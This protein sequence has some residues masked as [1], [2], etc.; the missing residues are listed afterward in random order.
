ME[1]ALRYRFAAYA[2]RCV[3]ELVGLVRGVV[4]DGEV[5]ETEVYRLAAWVE[6]NRVVTSSWPGSAIAQRLSRIFADGRVE[7]E[8]RADLRLLLEDLVAQPSA[9]A[10]APD[11]STRLPLCDPPPRVAYEPSREFVFTGR[12]VFGTRGHCE[13]AVRRRGASVGK[14][15]T[16]RTN[17]LVIGQLGSKAWVHSTHGR[18]IEDAVALRQRG[19]GLGIISEERWVASL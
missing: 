13:D 3:D 15:V 11:A 18:K 4:A 6:E 2:D 5:S 17:Y 1:Q 7:D 12:M 8:E 19:K 9:D 10:A 14:G 16:S